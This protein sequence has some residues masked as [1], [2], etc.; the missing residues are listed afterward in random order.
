MSEVD[1]PKLLFERVWLQVDRDRDGF[2]YAKQMPSFITQCEQVIKD[3]VNTNKTDFHMTRFKNRLKLPLLPKLHMDLIDAFAKETPYYKIYKESFSDMLNKLTGNNFSTVIN[4]IFEDCDGF[5]ASFI[6]ALE[7]KADVKSSPRSKA[8]S[9]G[10]PIKVDLLRN[11]KPQEEPET[12]R[13]INRKYKSLELQLESMK[14]ELEDKE[15]TIMNNE[16][17]LTELR[18]TIS[19][20]KEKYDLLSEEY[21]QRHIHGG[22]N[23]T[24]IKHDV[25]IGELKSRLQ[26]QNRLIR[27]LQEQIQFDPQLKRETR[28]HDN[29]SKNNTFN[30]AIAYVIPFLLFIFVIRSLI[31]KEDIGDATM[32][33]PWW[34][35]NNLASRLAWYF[36]DVFSNDSAKFLESDAYDKVFGIH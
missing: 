3:T 16:R 13:R 22:N 36:R 6:S 25:V 18:S 10:S 14:R 21:E 34:E 1:V 31:T 23:G 28:V 8:D 2:I 20:L 7:V 24:A 19:K 5:P 9:L 12:P 4:K 15:K 35:R 17:N 27:I 29:K 32:A 11:L 30:G 33:L 26:E